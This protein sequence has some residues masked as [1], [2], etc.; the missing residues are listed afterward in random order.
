MHSSKIT[1]QGIFSTLNPQKLLLLI[2]G[3]WYIYVITVIISGILAYLYLQHRLPIY[4]VSTTILIEE[5]DRT[6]EQDLLQGFTVRP[7]VQNLDN[8]LIIIKS[9]SLI[10]KVLEELPFDIDVFKKGFMSQ[11]S[12]F[13]MNPFRIEAG[14]DG[15][16]YNIEFVFNY[17]DGDMFYLETNTK[18]VPPLDTI[19]AFG[20]QIPYGNTSFTI[21]PHPGL[22][23]IYR[24]G[25]DIYIKFYDKEYLADSYLGRLQVE[26]P[27]RSGSIVKLSLQG[28]NK[29]MDIL[30]LNKLMEVYINDNLE[31]KNVEAKRVIDF[32]DSQLINV[33][34]SLEI[35]ETQLQE[36]RSKNRIMDVSA[37]AQQIINQAVIL[38]NEKARLNLEKNY[39]EYL[40]EYLENDKND[41]VPIAPT[42]MGII[43][44]M[45]TNLM[46]NLAAFQAEYFSSGAGDLNPM[47]A[48]LELRIRNTKQSIKENLSSLSQANQMAISENQNQ[49]NRLNSKASSLPEKERRLLGFERKFNLNNVLYTY[50]LQE[51]ADAQIQSASSTPDNMLV[52]PARSMGRVSPYWRNVY[53][54]AFALAIGLPVLFIV[55]RNLFQN[56]IVNEGDLDF[57]S[58]NPVIG[59]LPRS[60]LSYNTVVLN[61]PNSQ[62]AEAFR[63]LRTRL[64]FYT[65]NQTSSVILLSSSM[66]G[67]GK[68]FASVNLASA[69]SLA[70]KKT[71]LVGFDLRKPTVS[72]N[73][74]LEEKQGL[75]SYLIGQKELNEVIYKT[76]YENL[77]VLPSGQIPPNP[78]EL[79]SSSK[80]LEMFTLLKEMYE[81]IVVDSAPVGVVSDIY[82]IARFADAFLIVVR[83]NHTRRT[84]LG[85]TI[86]E[87]QQNK[88]NGSGLLLNDIRTKGMNYR[89]SYK[90]K[91]EYKTKKGKKPKRQYRIP[92]K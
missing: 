91:Y 34:E 25:E 17:A 5:E 52:D 40:D 39:F 81:Y 84:I 90:Y 11:S 76:E 71:L 9:Y 85:A 68:S 8:Q 61:E 2:L 89:Y 31:D 51:R 14:P 33:T 86:S 16:P 77:Y 27:A 65:S 28:T 26:L 74:S 45:L 75:T 20:N 78:G 88:I 30:F 18:N 66:P 83:H 62:I 57:L 46:Q 32:I 92:S 1:N 69:Y 4:A 35:T 80:A 10:R 73:F 37:Q 70:G 12:C 22:E 23:R 60:R 41:A 21:Y 58:D 36:F 48:Q 59:H 87:L 19:I 67:E 50:L 38:E 47:R 79:T 3:K 6:P 63:S 13:P 42:S 64:D 15:L 72:K 55:L 56:K 49:I 82:P 44:P 43:D 54:L 29:A 24:T 7:G 53:L